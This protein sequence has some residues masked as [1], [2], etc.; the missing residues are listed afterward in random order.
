MSDK[1]HDRAHCVHRN[2]NVNNNFY[3]RAA[4]P[5]ELVWVKGAGR[6]DLCDRMELIPLTS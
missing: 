1:P 4:E 3:K 6:V 2:V 5:K